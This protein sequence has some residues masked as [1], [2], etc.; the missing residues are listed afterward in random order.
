MVSY[1]GEDNI[2]LSWFYEFNNEINDEMN[3]RNYDLNSLTNFLIPEGSEQNMIQN[4]YTNSNRIISYLNINEDKEYDKSLLGKKRKLKRNI[5]LFEKCKKI[6]NTSN[7]SNIK[8]S[9]NIK[10]EENE[11]TKINKKG[12]KKVK[13]KTERVHNNES[14]DNMIRKIKVHLFKYIRDIIN[15]NFEDKSNKILKLDYSSIMC[16][17]RSINLELFN[18]TLKQIFSEERQSDK[19]KNYND[20][21]NEILIKKI[22]NGIIK[23]ERVKKILNLTFLEML[24]IFRR[25]IGR[26]KKKLNLIEEKLKGVNLFINNKYDGYE[27]FM[28]FTDI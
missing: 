21:E 14:A 16:L 15:Q 8:N 2:D 3:E 18:K 10:N 9:T 6:K 12:R 13:D 11:E 23:E 1:Q 7:E 28:T 19:Y 24:E 26:N 25:K 22:C 5:F 20:N 4:N 27:R 17:K